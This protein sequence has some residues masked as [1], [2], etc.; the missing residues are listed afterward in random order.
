MFE[1]KAIIYLEKQCF[2]KFTEYHFILND[3][4]FYKNVDKKLHKI[5]VYNHNTGFCVDF[6]AMT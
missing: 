2:L 3:C 1:E 5:L 6:L 4:K